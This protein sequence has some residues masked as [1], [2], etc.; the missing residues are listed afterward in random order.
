MSSYEEIFQDKVGQSSWDLDTLTD[1]IDFLRISFTDQNDKVITFIFSEF[2]AYR[3]I[4]EGDAINIISDISN[5]GVIG[6][7]FYLAKG[8]EFEEWFHRE[9][10]DMHRTQGVN[11]YLFASLNHVV[12]II[13]LDEPVIEISP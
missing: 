7:Y 2:L 9:S 4:D 3:S 6:K 5:A 13:S 1:S 11:S 10:F 8:S 12:E